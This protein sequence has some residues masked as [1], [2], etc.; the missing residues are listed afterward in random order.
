MGDEYTRKKLLIVFSVLFVVLIVGAFV[1]T[2]SPPHIERD[3][4]GICV[5]ALSADDARLVNASGAGWIRVDVSPDFGAAVVNARAYNLSVLGILGSWMFSKRTM[6]TLEEWRGNVTY[7]VSQY[8]DYVDAWEIWNEPANPTYPLLALDVSGRENMSQ[9]VQFYFLMVQVASPIIRQYDSS[10]KIV[11]FG[12]LNLWS[13]GAPHL[14]LD[15]EFA[16]Q[17][18]AMNVTQYGDALSVHA[19]PW[20]ELVESWVWGNYS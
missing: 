19:Y 13:G 5:H 16:L 17:L 15:K 20:G 18:A 4:V 8:A 9:V 12:G 3:S 11:L 10:A 2:V 7:Y 14:D 6:F 1:A